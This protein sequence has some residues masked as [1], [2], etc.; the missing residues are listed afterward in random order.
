MSIIEAARRHFG[1]RW[2]PDIKI[3][4]RQGYDK[5][6]TELQKEI[7]ELQRCCDRLRVADR[8]MATR[9][10]IGETDIKVIAPEVEAEL[11]RL[12][13]WTVSLTETV[14]YLVMLEMGSEDEEALRK[15]W[16]LNM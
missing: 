5:K 11:A 7:K 10:F 8:K 4:G 16:G 13:G 1:P 14:F 12:H 15:E 3:L 9:G 2:K 6:L